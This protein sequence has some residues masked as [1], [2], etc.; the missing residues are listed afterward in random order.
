MVAVG[1]GGREGAGGMSSKCTILPLTAIVNLSDPSVISFCTVV[2]PGRPALKLIVSHFGKSVLQEDGT[3]D[4]AKLGSII[5]ADSEKRK[6]LNRCTHP[7]IQRTMLWEVL[8]SLLSGEWMEFGRQ[9][10][11][12]R[13][14]Y[15]VKNKLSEKT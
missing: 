4:R 12:D 10:E 7:Y 2:E 8:T 5:F 6:V 9:S 13:K 1:G 11:L 15:R 3:L 14:L